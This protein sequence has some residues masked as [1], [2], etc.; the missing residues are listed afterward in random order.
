M[1]LRVSFK[2]ISFV[3]KIALPPVTIG[4]LGLD[5]VPIALCHNATMQNLKGKYEDLGSDVNF[6]TAFWRFFLSSL[7]SKAI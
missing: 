4:A 5:R 6:P 3:F 1:D 2:K 7:A